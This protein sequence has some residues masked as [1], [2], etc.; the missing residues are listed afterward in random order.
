MKKFLIAVFIFGLINPLPLI[1]A[2]TPVA[3]PDVLQRALEQNPDILAAQQFWKASAAQ[4]SP[5]K[6]WPNPTLTYIDEEFP[7]GMEGIPNE[8]ISHLRIEQMVPFPGKL[9]GESRMQYHEALIAETSYRSKQFEVLGNVRIGYYAL[10]LTDQKIALAKQSVETLKS[11]LQTAQSRLA[12]GQSTTSDIFMAQIELRKM[13]NR[14]FQE[15]QGRT[16]A[17]IELNT[18]L[19]QPTTTEWGPVQAPALIEFPVS[20]ADFQKLAQENNPQYDG[21]PKSSRVRPGF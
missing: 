12:S 18:L 1:S 14:L 21:E 13:E 10:Y 20:L 6:T 8:E 15:Q 16:L 17:Q 7:S 5:M 11:V 3:L 4:I 19:N 9:S 2:E